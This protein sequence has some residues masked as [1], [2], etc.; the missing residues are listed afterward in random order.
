MRCAN[1]IECVFLDQVHC[2]GVVLDCQ[3]SNKNDFILAEVKRIADLISSLVN[4]L[5]LPR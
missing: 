4:G 3:S 2:L 5:Q 1:V